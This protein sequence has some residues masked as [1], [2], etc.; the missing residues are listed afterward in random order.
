[1]FFFFKQK[2]AY[3]IGVRLVG[4]EMCIRDSL[5][6]RGKVN[7]S[8]IILWPWDDLEWPWAISCA[9][10]SE[11]LNMREKVNLSPII[12]WPWHDLGWPWVTLSLFCCHGWLMLYHERENR[13][14]LFWPWPWHDHGITFNDFEINLPL[15]LS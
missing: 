3:E 1:M 6:M 4:S 9:W 5:N 14:D 13:F 11:C 7:L 10:G 15:I 8:L 2:T 12:L